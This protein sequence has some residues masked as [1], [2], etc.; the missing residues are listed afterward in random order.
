M[1]ET[2]V[3]VIEN[4]DDLDGVIWV[5]FARARDNQ[6]FTL[7]K[8][9]VKDGKAIATDG[10]RL[11]K[12]TPEELVPDGLYDPL[13]INQNRV[14][15]IEDGEGLKYPDTERVCQIPAEVCGLS[16]YPDQA[17]SQILNRVHPENYFN[18]GY[19]LAALKFGRASMFHYSGVSIHAPAWG[20]TLL[21]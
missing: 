11:H 7:T 20:A 15:L 21:T 2:R 14:L 5:N 9:Q 17:I 19:L 1:K 16:P 10:R 8:L 4:K 18:V 13:I 12:Y 6:R 3:I